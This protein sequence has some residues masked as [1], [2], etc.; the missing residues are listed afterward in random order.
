MFEFHNN[1]VTRPFFGKTIGKGD[2]MPV[3]FEF[4]NYYYENDWDKV[5]AVL[6]PISTTKLPTKSE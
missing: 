1:D 4:V 3:K 2:Y 5:H 6:K